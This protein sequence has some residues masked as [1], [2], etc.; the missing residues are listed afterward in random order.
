MRETA[1]DKLMDALPYY[2]HLIK[3]TRAS[4]AL[5]ILVCPQAG[6]GVINGK[7][8][9]QEINITTDKKGNMALSSR[10]EAWGKIGLAIRANDYM[11]GT[12]NIYG[13]KEII[14]KEGETEWFHSN[15]EN[16]HFS[17]D[18]YVNAWTDYELWSKKRIF[19]QK[20]FIIIR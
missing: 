11:D 9:N 17:D 10:I 2:R 14:L 12:A 15:I 19:Y 1:T 3:D 7:S 13:V 20:C 18:R 5:E 4:K 16:Y 8:G 6:N